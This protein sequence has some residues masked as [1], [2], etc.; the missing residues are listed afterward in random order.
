[1]ARLDAT[2]RQHLVERY[3]PNAGHQVVIF[4]T[5]TEVD[6]LKDENRHF[7]MEYPVPLGVLPVVEAAIAVN[8][9]RDPGG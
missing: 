1:M 3:V 8:A 6:P 7:P 4:S 2:H 5:D 9:D